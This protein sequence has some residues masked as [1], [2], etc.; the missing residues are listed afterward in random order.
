MRIVPVGSVFVGLREKSPPFSIDEGSTDVFVVAEV[1]DGCVS[2]F[3]E[4]IRAVAAL[5]LLLMMLFVGGVVAVTSI[6]FWALTV[7]AEATAGGAFVSE[8]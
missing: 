6:C 5:L 1:V 7:A 4:D 3:D 2:S 8:G